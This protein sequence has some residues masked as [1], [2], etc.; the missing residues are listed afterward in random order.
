MATPTIG[1]VSDDIILG[2]FY[3]VAANKMQ[4]NIII[5]TNYY[6]TRIYG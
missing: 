3:L 6:I 5:L 1:N 2:K 4:F